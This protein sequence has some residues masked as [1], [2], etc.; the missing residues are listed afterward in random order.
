[1]PLDSR[2]PDSGSERRPSR[3]VPTSRDQN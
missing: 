1:M 2:Q 3:H